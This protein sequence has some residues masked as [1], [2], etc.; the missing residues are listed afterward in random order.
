MHAQT[1]IHAEASRRV[2]G[3]NFTRRPSIA[4]DQQRI[5]IDAMRLSRR[6]FVRRIT[7]A[8]AI[9]GLGPVSLSMAPTPSTPLAIAAGAQAG[10][11]SDTT[12]VM[13]QV[14]DPTTLDPHNHNTAL[15]N[16]IPVFS[17]FDGLTRYDANDQ[18]IPWL[19]TSWQLAN[20]T[21]W[22]FKIRSGVTFHNGEPFD[23]NTVQ[24]NLQRILAPDSK[25]LAATVFSVID[26]ATVVDPQTIQIVT[27]QA[28]PLL[29]KRFAA[30]GSPMLS[31]TYLQSVGLDQFIANPVG[32]GMYKF[33]EWVRDDHITLERNEDWWGTKPAF[34]RV[35]IRSIPNVPSMVAALVNGEVDFIQTLPTDQVS[36]VDGTGSTRST[37]TVQDDFL[38]L[39]CNGIN[40]QGPITQKLV[41]QAL[42]SAID[43]QSLATNVAAGYARPSYQVLA[44]TDVIYDQNPQ[45]INQDL[46]RAKALLAQA[47]Y[48]GEPVGLV[49]SEGQF[50]NDRALTEAIAAMGQQAGINTQVHLLEASVYADQLVKKSWD[51]ALLVPPSDQY[52]DPDGGL[53]RLLQSGGLFATWDNQAGI[54]L[55]AQAR[56]ILNEDDRW[57]L[58]RQAMPMLLDDAAWIPVVEDERVQGVS[59]RIDWKPRQQDQEYLEDFKL[60]S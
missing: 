31:P 52:F 2:G 29:P 5:D 22:E 36:V 1:L 55:M 23:A 34:Q 51:G 7:A 9:A 4:T 28:D 10:T 35:V 13:A 46:D 59:N 27:K 48:N 53:Y 33:V 25:L 45:P 56:T 8:L 26:H 37:A 24:G 12:L 21:T 58:Y 40:G 15:Q 54:D 18:L 3:M 20:D 57:P 49:T 47:G 50:P 42:S 30:W 16:D 32:T 41:R 44:P 17:I 11:P 39:L 38:I 43:R 14:S 60:K 19:A 6:S